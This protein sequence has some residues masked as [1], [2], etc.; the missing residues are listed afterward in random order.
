MGGKLRPALGISPRRLIEGDDD[1]GKHEDKDKAEE[2]RI[3]ENNGHRPGRDPPRIPAANT[4]TPMTRSKT[5]RAGGHGDVTMTAPPVWAELVDELAIEGVPGKPWQAAFLAV[6]REVFIP[7]VIWRCAGD[8]LVPLRRG[9]QPAEWLQRVYG[10]HYIIT[11][12]AD[13]APAG[14]GG[15]GRVVTS[16]ASRPDIVALMLAAGHLEPG[17]RVLEI[18]TGTG[19]TAALLAHRLGARNVTT[20]EVDPDLAARARAALGHVGYGEVTVITGDGARGDPNR[21][22][23][24]RVLST[25]AAPRVPY[26]WVTQT[27]PAG[28]GVTPWSS[29]YEPAG[30]LSLTVGPDGTATGGLVNTTI[31]FMPL[32]D[33]R[34]TRTTAADLVRDTDTAELSTTD[35]HARHLCTDD[36]SFAIGFQVPGCHWEYQPTT[37][38]DDRWAVWFLDPATR[39]WA[40]F[41]Y[42]PTT[43][44]WPVHQFGPRRLFDEVTAAYH[45]WNHAGGPPATHLRLTITQHGQ[46]LD[47][48]NTPRS[49]AGPAEMGCR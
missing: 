13:G 22:P 42:Q 45:Q 26:P 6:P 7:E 2:Q 31:S 40:R 43:Q 32:R 39:S 46:Q 29:A 34:I 9:D 21:A 24:D 8:D 41:D 28:L 15:R 37:G 12:V 17:M 18:G 3:I 10:P 25:A 4:A 38:D 19:Y 1:M 5:T 20:I 48:T 47:L 14:P 49:T 36:A 44:R 11:Q 27:R 16:S 30:L 23:F 33:Q 35:L